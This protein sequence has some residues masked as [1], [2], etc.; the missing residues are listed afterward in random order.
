MQERERERGDGE[1]W[2]KKKRKK[3]NERGVEA[4]KKSNKLYSELN[5]KIKTLGKKRDYFEMTPK[6]YKKKQKKKLKRKLGRQIAFFFLSMFN[7]K[8]Q[9]IFLKIILTFSNYEIT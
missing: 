9:N 4:G 8:D 2:G 5:Q 3:E 7:D 1:D 6:Q